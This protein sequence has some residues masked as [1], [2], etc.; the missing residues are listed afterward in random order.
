MTSTTATPPPPTPPHA[1]PDAL[2]FG[3]PQLHT[4]GDILD[5]RFAADGSLWSIEEPG[6]VRHW[7][8][9]TGQELSWLSLSDLEELWRFSADARLLASGSRDD[10]AV[11]DA[12]SGAL[13][14]AIPQP[15]QVTALAFAPDPGFVATGHEDGTVRYWDAAAHR[16]LHEFRGHKQAISALAVSPDGKVLASAGED[17]II[18]L[19]DLTRGQLA[20]TLNGHPSRIPA[21]AWHPGGRYLV[22]AG[23][24]TTARIWDTHTG[25]PVILLNSHAEQVNAL[26]FSHDG[27]LLAC[28]D[29]ENAV[30]IWDFATHTTS[31]ILRGTAE[32]IHC[33]TFDHDSKRLAVGGSDRVIHLWDPQTGTPLSSQ[34]SRARSPGRLA[35]SPNGQ[36]L[37]ANG[38][39]SAPR[40]WN[41]AQRTAIPLAGE[42][43]VHALAWSAR[44]LIAG[45]TDQ[46]VSLWDGTTGQPQAQLHGQDEPTTAVAFTADGSLLASASSTGL[47]VWIWDTATREPTLLIPDP[48]DGCTVEALAFHPT[49]RVL[50]VGG[51]DWLATGGSDG[52][53]SLWDLDQRAEI[54]TFA[55]G[56]TALAWHP[57]GTRLAT[58]ALDR[59]LQVWA[60]GNLQ[61]PLAELR[62]HEDMPR[63][64]AFSPDGKLLASGGD[65]RTVRLWDVDSGEE[66]AARELDTQVQALCFSPDGRYLFTANGNTTCYRL[67]VCVLLSGGT[68]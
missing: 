26:A 19:W 63:A 13:R 64:V 54:A 56:V 47:P 58:A 8:P 28:A 65:D 1:V 29:S 10:I 44:G 15:D 23:W 2:V 51:I 21:L 24:D 49:R 3:D 27:S 62:G 68:L 22:S 33:L 48:L 41:I 31:R 17:R 37:A 6:V 35:L 7:N 42:T 25:Q 30:H 18:A 20:G 11:W 12:S 34:S 53:V 45:G 40:I 60:P 66:L 16:L 36:C 4:E 52:A 61:A 50:A 57:D 9:V 67:E 38:G 32:D 43:P 59:S 39:G 55:N 14:A 5:L 46:G